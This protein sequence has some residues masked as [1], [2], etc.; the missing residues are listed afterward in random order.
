M[1]LGCGVG[2]GLVTQ[3]TTVLLGVP[4]N[5]KKSCSVCTENDA[6]A[7]RPLAEPLS[8]DEQ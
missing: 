3:A 7:R 8:D 6:R 2:G 1:V 4:D 5:N